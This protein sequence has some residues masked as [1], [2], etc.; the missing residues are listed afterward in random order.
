MKIAYVSDQFLPA[1]SA[2]TEQF[3]NMISALSESIDVKLIAA[4]Y[5][6]K[7]PV[8]LKELKDYYLIEGNFEID[9][10]R[11]T[12]PQVRGPEKQLIA[13]KGAL[14]VKN[15]EFID[16]V[17]TRN[18]GVIIATLILT[19]KPVIFETFRPWPY[20]NSQSRWFFRKLVNHSRFL[21]I[22]LHSAFAKKAYL[23][24][25][26]QEEQLLVEHNAFRKEFFENNDRSVNQI[27]S[28]LGI[29]SSK[30]VITYT[31]RVT[32]EKGLHYFLDLAEYFKDQVFLIIG[33]EG[34]G[35]IERRAKKI[36]NVLV[37]PW[38]D[39]QATAEYISAS[40]ILY[41]PT[42]LRA[43]EKAM[44]TVL[45]LK[46][47]IYKAS[48]KAIF[49]P[50]I[51]DIREVLEHMKTAYLVDPDNKQDAIF[52]MKALLEDEELQSKIGKAAKEEMDTLTWENRAKNVI[53]FI[54]KRLSVLN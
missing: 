12:I 16:V 49:A 52:G 27:R 40:D 47:F 8:S 43:R 36:S 7:K 31:G 4:N 5:R 30:K 2:D 14:K 20:R 54:E 38:Q 24:I 51:A 1:S 6:F 28:E 3:M 48:G 13:V 34:E 29:Q 32:T 11:L 53:F 46:T 9:N 42:S 18:I 45:P 15:D 39:K 19:D 41:I 10:V 50:D 33:S 23:E 26:F 35:E 21:G 37:L 44:N 17:Y 22:I 25:G